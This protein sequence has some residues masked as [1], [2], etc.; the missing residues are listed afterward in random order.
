MWSPWYLYCWSKQILITMYWKWKESQIWCWKISKLACL[1]PSW[2]SN[3]LLI[4]FI[5][6]P[7]LVFQKNFGT[8]LTQ[9]ERSR[10]FS[11]ITFEELKILPKNIKKKELVSI[12]ISHPLQKLQL[13]VIFFLRKSTFL[14]DYKNF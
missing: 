3:V 11:M 14:K 10:Y 9:R 7:H 5:T 12:Y 1:P 13:N 4:S 2:F 6:I 8:Y